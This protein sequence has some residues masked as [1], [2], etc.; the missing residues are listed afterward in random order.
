MTYGMLVGVKT[1]EEDQARKAPLQT[2]KALESVIWQLSPVN[3]KLWS[4]WC[5]FKIF[6]LQQEIM[7]LLDLG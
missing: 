1:H 2:L 7:T 3:L 5:P 6:N 4:P